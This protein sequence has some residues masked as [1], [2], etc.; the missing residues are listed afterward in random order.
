MVR[1]SVIIPT[2][3]DP[4]LGNTVREVLEKSRTQP[5]VIVMADA[6]DVD[7][8]GAKIVKVVKNETRLGLRGNVNKGMSLASGEWLAKIDDHCMLSDGW[9]EVLL[10]SVEKDWIVVPRRYHL[11]PVKWCIYEGDTTQIDYERLEINNP[12]KIGGVTWRSRRKERAD[13]LLDETMVIQGSFYLLHRDHWR[14]IGPLDEANYGPFTQEGIEI[15]LK[16]WLG[17]G[18]VMVNKA[19]WYAHKHRSFGRVVSPRGTDVKRGNAY[20]KDFWMNDRW[21]CRKHDLSWLMKRFGL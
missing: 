4:A 12:D 18:K 16:T 21:E 8:P 19:A 3:N 5:E 20:S 11:D 14:R 10:A 2:V 1:I 6:V 13:I 9:D 7:I 15:A 17:G